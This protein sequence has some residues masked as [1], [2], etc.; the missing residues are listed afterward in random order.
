[1]VYGLDDSL[2]NVSSPLGFV[3]WPCSRGIPVLA[4]VLIPSGEELRGYFFILTCSDIQKQ[5]A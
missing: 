4:S 5:A 1:M 2:V 3:G